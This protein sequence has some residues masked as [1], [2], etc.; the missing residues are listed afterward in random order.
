[1]GQAL[2]MTLQQSGGER[3]SGCVIP[4]SHC[5]TCGTLAYIRTRAHISQ[6]R[7]S[8]DVPY[9]PQGCWDWWGYSGLDYAVRISPQILTV[10][11]MI[12]AIIGPQ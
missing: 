2:G 1:M 12:D 11:N 7:K 4:A 3:V 6:T 10:R 8:P 9:N 5:R